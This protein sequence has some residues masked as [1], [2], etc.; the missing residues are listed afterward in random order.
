MFFKVLVSEQE[1]ANGEHYETAKQCA[2]EENNGPF[3][4]VDEYD[5]AKAVL[6]LCE[7]W[8]E[9]TTLNVLVRTTD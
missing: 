7:N 8:D 6:T 1:L 4:V 3:W 5:P 9:V 2:N